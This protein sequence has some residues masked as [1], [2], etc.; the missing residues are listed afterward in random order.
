MS[1]STRQEAVFDAIDEANAVDPRSTPVGGEG[2]AAIPVEL[3]YGLRM[4]EMCSSF[5]PDADELVQIAARGQ[6]IE[7]WIIP[8]DDY[9]RDRPGYHR[10]RNALKKHH[11]KRVSEIMAAQ[12]YGAEEC[13]IVSNILLKKNLK[14][15]DRT[16]A[17]EDLACLVFLQYYA[18]DF[19]KSH[20]SEKVVNIIAKTLPKMSTEAHAFAATLPLAD[21]IVAAIEAAKAKLAEQAKE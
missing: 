19:A 17:V 8:R 14:R 20:E 6:H 16:Q 15:D 13:E 5:A 7:R 9:P 1:S 18:E 10:W 21:G 11:A 2:M 4:S 12:S 3:I